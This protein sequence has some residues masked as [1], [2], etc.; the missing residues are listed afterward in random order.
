M[1]NDDDVDE[2][3]DGSQMFPNKTQMYTLVYAPVKT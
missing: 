1:G 2:V 3:I